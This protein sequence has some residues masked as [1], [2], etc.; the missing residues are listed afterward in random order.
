[1]SLKVPPSLVAVTTPGPSTASATDPKPAVVIP[2]GFQS[3]SDIMRAPPFGWPPEPPTQS[4]FQELEEALQDFAQGAQAMGNGNVLGALVDDLKGLAELADAERG[5]LPQ[6]IPYRP[7]EPVLNGYPLTPANI[8]SV[9]VTIA[10]PGGS[11]SPSVNIGLNLPA[12]VTANG[13][14]SVVGGN[15]V[16]RL[17]DSQVD[18]APTAPERNQT[19]NVPFGR[20]PSSPGQHQL[21]IEDA[22]GKVLSTKPLVTLPWRP[23]CW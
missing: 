21:I 9:G 16:V 8:Q 3:G 19:L 13:T 1:M 4:P 15:V 22:N 11:G 14:A 17:S 23:L 12:N 20:L 18:G 2:D 6:P 10:N 7:L 5:L